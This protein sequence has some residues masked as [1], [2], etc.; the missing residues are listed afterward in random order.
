MSEL[1][2]QLVFGSHSS[3]ELTFDTQG[4]DTKVSV[5]DEELLWISSDDR[6]NFSDELLEL[7]KKYY[8]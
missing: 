1:K 5:G 3:L 4:K 8:I 6:D 7:L 2:K